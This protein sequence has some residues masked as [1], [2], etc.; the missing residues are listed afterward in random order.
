METAMT[1]HHVHHRDPRSPHRGGTS[2]LA[3][4]IAAATIVGLL[5][6]IQSAPPGVQPPAPASADVAPRR[7]ATEPLD[8]GVDWQ[9]MEHAPEANGASVAAYER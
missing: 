7:N 6:L 1:S 8:A 4:S 2:V 5:T 9:R 3:A